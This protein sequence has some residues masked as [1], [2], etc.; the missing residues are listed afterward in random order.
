MSTAHNIVTGS[1]AQTSQNAREIWEQT[2][3]GFGLPKKRTDDGLLG[4]ID[5]AKQFSRDPSNIAEA[6]GDE[7][8]FLAAAMAGEDYQRGTDP[9]VDEMLERAAQPDGERAVID[10]SVVGDATPIEVD[11]EIVNILSE[12]APVVDLVTQEAQA[13]FTAQYNVI[14]ER[15]EPIGRVAESDAIDLSGNSVGDFGLRTETREMK[16]YVDQVELSDFTQRAEDSLGYMDVEET[17][18]GVRTAQYGRYLAGE[19]IYGDPDVGLSNGSIQDSNAAF[20]MARLAQKA[21]ANLSTG[22]SHEV[23]ESGLATGGDRDRLVEIKEQLT[24][25][26]TNTGA[27]YTNL[28]VLVGPEL[29]DVLE[30]ELD[31]IVRFDEFDQ[32]VNFG[33]RQLNVKGVPISETRAVGRTEHG[34]YT[35][36]GTGATPAG[37]LSISDGDALIFDETAFRHRQLAP[38]STV[39]LG[40]VGL[41]DKAA[42]FAYSAN[43]DKSQGAHLKFLKDIPLA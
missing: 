29:F 13:G 16:I 9:A 19:L 18:L 4:D 41:A 42:M 8:A 34:G 1:G 21:D 31:G 39:P 27:T 17:T 6:Y 37:N 2:V 25:L 7:H 36:N 15:N 14:N 10:E 30:Q 26:V 38:L 35:Y 22:I 20:G 32:N 28:H 24:E 11:P 3:D 40:R 33:G 43:V 12:A 23:D 5:A